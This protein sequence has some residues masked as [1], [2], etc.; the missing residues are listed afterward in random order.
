L[1]LMHEHLNNAKSYSEGLHSAHQG[2]L[3]WQ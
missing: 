3:H 2:P 1:V